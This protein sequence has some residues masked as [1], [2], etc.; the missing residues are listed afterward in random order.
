MSVLKGVGTGVARRVS[1]LAGWMVLLCAFAAHAT[2]GLDW[3]ATQQSVDG[4]YGG[5]PDSLATPVQSTAEV[6]R[7]HQALGQTTALGFASAI[8]FLN[9]EAGT[10]TE[11]LARKILVNAQQG[12]TVDVA[13]I[14]QLLSRQNA[15]GGFGD[16]P[17]YGSSVLDTAVALEAL[18]A[19]NQATSA[20]SVR[21]IGFLRECQQSNGGWADGANDASV[22]LTA[23]SMRA[24]LPYRTTYASV[25]GGSLVGRTSCFPGVARM[26]CGAGIS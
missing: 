4:S 14:S 7:A 15:D 16:R 24:L 1:V 26:D 12:Y 13:W 3:L 19:T 23:A 17:G 21:A 25:A 22:Y 5:G 6:L 18:A 8:G 20:Q 2:S 10:H 9:L 11:F